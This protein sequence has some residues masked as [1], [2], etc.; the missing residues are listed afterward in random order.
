MI[1]FHSEKEYICMSGIAWMSDSS[2]FIF[3]F[4]AIS[5]IFHSCVSLPLLRVY[6]APFLH[7]LHNICYYLFDKCH[8]NRGDVNLIVVLICISLTISG[9]EQLFIYLFG[10]IYHLYIFLKN[11]FSVLCPFL[12]HINIM[13]AIVLSMFLTYFGY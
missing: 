8:P 9:T 5:I 13:N 4:W 12:N 11:V 2:V 1:L 10:N 3:Y 6:R 7:I